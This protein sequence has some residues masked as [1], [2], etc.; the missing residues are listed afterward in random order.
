MATTSRQIV[1]IDETTGLEQVVSVDAD[2]FGTGTIAQRPVSGVSAGDMYVVQD[3][4][5]S[6]YRIDIYDGSAW[7]TLQ[8]DS[9]IVGPASATDEAVV[10]YDGTTGKLTQNSNVTISDSGSIILQA[11]ETVDGRDVSVDGT[12]LDT[13]ETGAEVNDVT[14]VF[15]RLG[16]IV[17]QASD[18]DAIQIDYNNT[19][20][21]LSAIEVQAAIDEIISGSL[22]GDFAFLYDAAGG[23]SI[24]GSL[25]SIT[26]DS[27]GEISSGFSHTLNSSEITV[28]R[29]GVYF[30]HADITLDSTTSTRTSSQAI[31]Q[32]DT[33]SGFADV[34]GSHAW[35]YHRTTGNGEGTAT[36]A[37]VL[38]LSPGD[39]IRVVAQFVGGTALT[40]VANASRLIIFNTRGPQGPT[41]A[42]SNINVFNEGSTLPN[43]PF[44]T[45]NFVGPGITAT[46]AGS[47]Q[48]DVTLSTAVVS[49]L[50]PDLA[51]AEGSADSLAR[52]D[53]IHNIPA[54]V[55]VTLTPDQ[56]NAEGTNASFARSNHVHNI[57]TAT[58]VTVSAGGTNTQGSAA[59]FARSDHVHR[60]D[61]PS[62]EVT[63]T[64]NI[65]TTSGTP[66]TATSMT[67]TPGEGTYLVWFSAW[68]EHNN[69]FATVN[70][71]IAVA[72]VDVAASEREAG[73]TNQSDGQS[74]PLATTARVTITAGQEI[75]GRYWRG[76]G[77]GA[78]QL[79]QRTLTILKV[80]D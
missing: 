40:S 58:P 14:S 42:G 41:G 53:H 72:G 22:N 62:T 20:S 35:G 55:V 74:L 27:Q 26:W 60:I 39:V 29:A 56:A 61:D 31:I 19:S 3:G 2:I 25:T 5:L 63:A 75:Q 80:D 50:T 69:N 67:I 32:L 38:L 66:I 34:D 71:G 23:Q 68:G 33:G 44:D 79:N 43:G 73:G 24:P 8:S 59:T 28:Q 9:V 65:S 15:G 13:I 48:A 47:A 36:A 64:G 21:G 37:A 17:A 46:D 78:V 12:K 1:A 54:A 49:T 76:N 16:S 57:P 30:V 52:S 6:V 10:R 77:G 18:Y 51:N 4:G 70:I 11:S 7:T 45:L